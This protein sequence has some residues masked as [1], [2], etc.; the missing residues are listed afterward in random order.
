MTYLFNRVPLSQIPEIRLAQ[1]PNPLDFGFGVPLSQIPEIRLAQIP[2]S[3]DFGFGVPLSQIP[4]IRLA[5]KKMKL[6]L[7]QPISSTRY[8]GSI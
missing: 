2:N 5:Q 7:S 1:I 6:F 4:E 3:S 8:T